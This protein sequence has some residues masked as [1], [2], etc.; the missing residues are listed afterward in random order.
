M[1]HNVGKLDTERL[2]EYL[3][4]AVD[5]FRGP[6]ETHK[7]ANGQSNPTFRLEAA[8]GTYV[9]RRQPPGKILKSAHA[10]DGGS[11]AI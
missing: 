11:S 1:T 6:I 8:S 9:L 5:G 4:R 3:E 2:R 10:V 7:F